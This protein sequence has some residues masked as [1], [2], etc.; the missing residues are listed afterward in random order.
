MS[1]TEEQ[2]LE[3]Y[4]NVKVIMNN[5]LACKQVQN[6]HENRISV[7][8]KAYWIFVGISSVITFV[9]PFVI[10]HFMGG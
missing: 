3:M 5:C 6:S 8:E 10:H 9:L 4:A 1:L 2:E 7:L